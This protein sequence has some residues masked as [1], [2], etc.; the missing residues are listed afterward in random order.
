MNRKKTK[1]LYECLVRIQS[2]ESLETCL[3][4]YPDLET[5]LRPM[6]EI[7]LSLD[8]LRGVTPSAAFVDHA[9]SNIRVRV[10]EAAAAKPRRSGF[11][12]GFLSRTPLRMAA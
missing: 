3:A 8:G 1:A 11:N 6:L 7:T 2:G 10:T 9:W 12:L 5:E 4:I